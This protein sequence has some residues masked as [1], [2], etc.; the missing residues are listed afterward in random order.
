MEVAMTLLYWKFFY[1]HGS[2]H[3]NDITTYAHPVFLYIVPAL[4]LMIEYGLN[5]I[6]FDYK[7]IIHLMILYA[8]FIPFTYLGKF[9]LGYFPYPFIDWSTWY[10]YAVLIALGIMQVL[11]FFGLAFLSNYLKSRYLMKNME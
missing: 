2:M 9:V 8:I 6:I 11:A 1:S 3:A 10:S 5:Q 4:F 7:K